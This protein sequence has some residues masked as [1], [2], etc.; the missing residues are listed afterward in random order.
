[1]LIRCAASAELAEHTINQPNHN[2]IGH[3]F[4]ASNWSQIVSICLHT[5]EVEQ[6]T[7]CS[8]YD[9]N[10]IFI[11]LEHNDASLCLPCSSPLNAS[12]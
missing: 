11:H 6:S 3:C 8:H 1:M 10:L 2:R 7:Y 12:L 4:H 5:I 9:M